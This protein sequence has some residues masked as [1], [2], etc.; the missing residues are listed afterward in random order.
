MLISNVTRSDCEAALASVNAAGTAA[1]SDATNADI[2]RALDR[3][4]S[5]NKKNTDQLASVIE[6]LK[7][8]G[9]FLDAPLGYTAEAA[10]DAGREFLGRFGISLP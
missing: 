2:V 3:M 9:K 1:K 8:V 7:E 10:G 5:E 6:G 4:I